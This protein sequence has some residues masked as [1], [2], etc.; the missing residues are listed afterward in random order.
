MSDRAKAPAQHEIFRRFGKLVRAMS[1]V[2][3]ENLRPL[4]LG[5]QQAKL[6]RFIAEGHGSSLSDFARATETDSGAVVRLVDAMEKK[7]LIARKDDPEDRRRWTITLTAR[8]R[9]MATRVSRVGSKLERR[10]RNVLSPDE[11]K[12][13]ILLLD[14]VIVALNGENAPKRTRERPV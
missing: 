13:L 12:T 10:V 2:A 6:L 8:G 11:L 7:D 1:A 5:V 9:G 3:T 14:K 4:G